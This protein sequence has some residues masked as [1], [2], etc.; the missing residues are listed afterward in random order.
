MAGLWR[1]SANRI[2]EE[3]KGRARQNGMGWGL[4]LD[5]Q[6]LKHERNLGTTELRLLRLNKLR[7]RF[8][9]DERKVRRLTDALTFREILLF[10]VFSRVR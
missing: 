6:K 10:P 7:G 2:T 1:N 3:M 5:S 9:L 8:A 4:R